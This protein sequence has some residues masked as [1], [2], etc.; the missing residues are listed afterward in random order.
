MRFT[1][2]EVTQTLDVYIYNALKVT[3]NIAASSAVSV[4]QSLV[5]LILV[6]TANFIV[7]KVDKEDAIF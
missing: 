3:P 7:K 1:L 6:V 4:F 5:G 2:Y